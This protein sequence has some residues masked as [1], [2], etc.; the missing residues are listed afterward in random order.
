MAEISEI[1]TTLV[2]RTNEN[3]VLWQTT[4]NEDTFVALVG[5]LS[6][7]INP[8]ATNRGGRGWRL[9]ILNNEG[10]VIETL[11]SLTDDGSIWEEELQELYIKARRVAL[12][13]DSQL[14]GLLDELE[15]L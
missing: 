13:T 5:S 3:K 1:L 2:D 11:N 12:G 15:E 8:V 4:T 14:Q 10:R 9:E 7:M 6:V